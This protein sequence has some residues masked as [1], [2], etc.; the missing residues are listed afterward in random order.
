MEMMYSTNGV[1]ARN[2]KVQID[3][4]ILTKVEFL[5][6]GCSGN[7]QAVTRLVEG[8]PI[9]EVVKKCEGIHCGPRDTSCVDQ[10][11]KAIKIACDGK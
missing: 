9:D 10:L 7:L 3:D 5:N 4:G 2:I 6:G 8:M 1:C 11:T